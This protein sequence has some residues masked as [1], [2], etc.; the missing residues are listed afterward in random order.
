MSLPVMFRRLLKGVLPTHVR[1]AIHRLNIH[2]TDGRFSK[3]SRVEVFDT[4]YRERM[5]GGAPERSSGWGS[6]GDHSAAYVDFLR[7]FVV[8]RHVD[9][10]LDIGCGDFHIGS[11]VCERVQTV[12]GADVST[13]IVARNRQSFTHLKNVEFRQLDV[14]TDP[15]PRVDLITIREVLQHLSNA[16][17]SAALDN[18]QGSGAKFCLVTEHV[19][20][21]E[22]LRRPNLDKP[23]GPNVRNP[24]GSG[25]YIDK[26]P[27][28]RTVETV[29]SVEHPSFA[30]APSYL[31][32]SLWKLRCVDR[33]AG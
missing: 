20:A 28:D 10:I 15:L 6:Y 18:V 2:M 23:R 19:P 32:T 4:I 14:C 12:I 9:S 3:F 5:W 29:L 24:Y 21:P 25:V 1:Q 7:Q 11:Q 22:V 26:P 31:V 33:S 16:D 17:I 30:G 8:D 13:F 27:F